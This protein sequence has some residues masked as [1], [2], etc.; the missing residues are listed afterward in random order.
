MLT[1]PPT[2]TAS[3]AGTLRERCRALGLPMWRCDNAGLVL[4]EPD[5]TGAPG[6]FVRS[7]QMARL[8]S[9]AVTRM[10]TTSAPGVAEPA[11]GLWV[12][13]LPERHRRERTGW[14]ATAAMSPEFLE[15]ECFVQTCAGVHLDVLPT[16]IAL[17]P[18]AVHDR[19]S[20]EHLAAMLGWAV[21]DLLAA[22]E[23]R[24]TIDG[25]T[26][27]L[28][29]G[30]ETIDLLYAL[31]RYMGDPSQPQE[32]IRKALD[33]LT[34]SMQFGWVGCWLGADPRARRVQ[35]DRAF[36]SGRSA[37][38][39]ARVEAAARTLAA[40]VT[41]D[42][43]PLILNDTGGLPL[44]PGTQYLVQPV[45]RNGALLGVLIAGDKAGDDPQVSS[46]DIH[47]LEAAGAF[48]AAFLENAIL[49]AE[50]HAMFVGSL[51]ALTASIDA[52][53]RYTFGHSERVAHMAKRIALAH[54]LPEATAERLHICG[55]VHDVGKIGVPEAVLLK[56]GKLTDAEF[57]AIKLH[58][59][60]GYRILKDIPLMEDILPGVLHHHE[61]FDG[62]GYPGRLAGQDIPLFG[63]ILA[64]ADTFDAMSSN[65]SYRPALPRPRVLEEIRRCAGSQFDPSMVEAFMTLD[66]SSFDALVDH[67][68]RNL[69]G[70]ISLAA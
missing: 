57:E 17:R 70:A 66:L 31:G 47:L 28:T 11:P 68:R 21:T 4:E 39:A 6:L 63:R 67:H 25:F 15:S 45:A 52:K 16:R 42:S 34:A 64:V 43:K 41:A 13:G 30:F 50:Q 7:G 54:G 59:D 69:A 36:S 44:P 65:R 22:G 62:R 19:A 10:T 20:V 24:A 5:L 55:L 26:R 40:R 9:G 27:Q 1:L 37:P 29:D 8:V 14:L 46:Y 32:F 38:D 61:R 56:P 23:A 3:V 35:A 60:I 18:L 48:I 53:D 2:L 12:I 33:R 58:P 49:Y 51:T